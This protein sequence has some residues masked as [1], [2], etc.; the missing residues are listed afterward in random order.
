MGVEISFRLGVAPRSL[1][2]PGRSVDDIVPRRGRPSRTTTWGKGQ[3]IV[4]RTLVVALVFAGLAVVGPHQARRADAQTCVF[5]QNITSGPCT[6]WIY[7]EQL[8]PFAE[9]TLQPWVD[10]VEQTASNCLQSCGSTL[11]PWIDAIDQLAGIAENVAVGVVNECLRD[12]QQYVDL[13][14]SLVNWTVD[15]VCVQTVNCVTIAQNVINLVVGIAQN[16]IDHPELLVNIVL[17]VLGAVVDLAGE[18]VPIAEYYGGYASGLLESE[19]QSV[20]STATSLANQ[21]IGLVPDPTGVVTGA[22]A[23]F[24]DE[25][26]TIQETIDQATTVTVDG[27]TVSVGGSG[28]QT[29][30]SGIKPTGSGWNRG[31]RP[32]LKKNGGSRLYRVRG[33]NFEHCVRTG[34]PCISAAGNF[35][36]EATA[37]SHALRALA[38]NRGGSM[39]ESIDWEVGKMSRYEPNGDP[40][41]DDDNPP[42]S[43]P[44]WRIDI[45]VANAGS[46]N[47]YYELFEVKNVDNAAQ[48]PGQLLGYVNNLSAANIDGRFSPE[49]YNQQWAVKY[50]DTN[51]LIWYAWADYP[52]NRGIILFGRSDDPKVVASG[53]EGRAHWADEN[54]QT[55][56]LKAS[57]GGPA[58]FN[59]IIRV[60]WF[61]LVPV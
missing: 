25:L 38:I 10:Y 23:D 5:Y 40:F 4:A 2:A 57:S 9:Q 47:P 14:V 24:L 48:A 51:G 27:S 56:E 33:Y 20:L 16:Y 59:P 21:V 31:S 41:V 18:V 35:K 29:G 55:I 30:D 11:Q 17:T 12:C 50:H 32:Y 61:D 60:P 7:E 45:A 8:L 43:D 28:A 53:V 39:P 54:P 22:A 37:Q 19:L 6:L 26:P 3:S 15:T 49:L 1:D 36:P 13:V 52:S 34:L 42:A 58:P 44:A 46:G